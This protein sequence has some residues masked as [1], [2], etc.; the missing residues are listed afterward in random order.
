M[1]I[2]SLQVLLLSIENKLKIRCTENSTR[3]CAAGRIVPLQS[4]GV[5]LFFFESVSI[6]ALCRI[7]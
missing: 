3:V 7:S 6:F 4:L 2:C 5:A 1:Q